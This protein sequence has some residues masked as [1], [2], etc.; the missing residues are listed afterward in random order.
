MTFPKSQVRAWMKR[1]N[2][3]QKGLAHALNL[4]E[5]T[6]CFVFQGKRHLSVEAAKRLSDLSGIPVEKLLTGDDAV[7]ILKVLGKRMNSAA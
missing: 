7:Q 5:T 3:S 4:S 6:I 2:T 1:T